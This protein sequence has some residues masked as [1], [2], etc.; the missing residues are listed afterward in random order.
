MTD[1]PDDHMYNH[2]AMSRKQVLVQLDDEMVDR[3]DDLA[4]KLGVSRSELLRRGAQTLLQEQ[5]WA[6]ADKALIEAYRRTPQD[7]AWVE[8][9]SRL[10]AETATEW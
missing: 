9:A 8:S 4:K 10:A 5:E 7:Q 6:E 2:M 3:L 1:E